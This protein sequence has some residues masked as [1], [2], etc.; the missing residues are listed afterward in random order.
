MSGSHP[1]YIFF[2]LLKILKLFHGSECLQSTFKTFLKPLIET[3]L[4]N[5]PY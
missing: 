5:L 1:D 4:L 2:D 3:I